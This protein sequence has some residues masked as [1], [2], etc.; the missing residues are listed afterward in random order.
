MATTYGEPDVEAAVVAKLRALPPERRRRVLAFAES[1]A[2]RDGQAAG[3]VQ[4][5]ED[6]ALIARYIDNVNVDDDHPSYARLADYA[7]PVWAIIGTWRATD[8]VEQVAGE[9]HVSVEYVRAAL[10]YYR[11]FGRYID[12]LL[13]LNQGPPYEPDSPSA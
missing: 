7:T 5:D 8:D 1:L 3:E 10:A 11:R 9:W 12:A 4:T 6:D 2:R 13:L